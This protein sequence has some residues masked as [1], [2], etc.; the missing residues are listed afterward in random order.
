MN[1]SKVIYILSTCDEW[2]S[3]SS[4][5]IRCVSTSF[6][7]ILK[8]IRNDIK[9]DDML[10]RSDNNKESYKLLNADVSSMKES[11]WS[12]VEIACEI[13]KCL[14]YG[15]LEVWEDGETN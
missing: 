13:N 4:M 12:G 3:Y 11:G 5:S 9:A 8:V 7:K 1:M 2:E 6:N 15:Y 14:K 10:Y